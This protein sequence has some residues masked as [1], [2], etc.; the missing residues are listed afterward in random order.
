MELFSKLNYVLEILFAE[1]VF[2]SAFPRRKLFV[3]RFVPAIAASCAVGY[4]IPFRTSD[5]NAVLQFLIILF[6]L[7]VT[8]AGMYFSFNGSFMSVLSACCAGVAVQHIGHHLS[9]LIGL[10]PFVDTWN[11]MLEFGTCAVLCVIVF[12]TLGRML[13]KDNA[14]DTADISVTAVSVIIVLICIGITR[15]L[16]LGGAMNLYTTICTSVYAITCCLLALFIRFFLYRFIRLKSEHLVLQHIRE[17]ERRQ[18]ELDRENA[19]LLSVKC[20]DLKHVLLSLE[21][22]LPKEEINSLRE[23]VESYDST[24]HTGLDVLDIILNEKYSRCRSKDIQLTCMG[25]GVE[26][27]FM[28]IMDVYSLFGNILENAITAVEKIEV[29]GKRLISLIIEQKGSF[30]MISAKNYSDTEQLTFT[31]GLP[32]TTK[33]VEPGYHGYGLKSIQ[34]IAKKYHGDISVSVANGMFQVNIYMMSEAA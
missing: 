31:D 5:G 4:T 8:V 7:A 27:D 22:R 21:A 23:I 15:F 28:D 29:P 24:Y 9:R 18:F 26:L 12:F 25:S 11:S 34:L 1:L 13:K 19:E 2:L 32:N 17:E 14:Y 20:H 33:E 3:L 16:R 10:L 30:V 6:T